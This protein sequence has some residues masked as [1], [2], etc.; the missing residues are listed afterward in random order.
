MNA[1]LLFIYSS[2]MNTLVLFVFVSLA[3]IAIVFTIWFILY[4]LLHY[5]D[6]PK[7]VFSKNK[8]KVTV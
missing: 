5:E 7:G 4:A 8:N 1:L 3:V 2:F 6:D